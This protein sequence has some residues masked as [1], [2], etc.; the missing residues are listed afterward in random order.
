MSDN[1][2]LDE[3]DERIMKGLCV[4]CGERKSTTHYL[5]E[6]RHEI[7]VCQPCF[8]IE[9]ETEMVWANFVVEHDRPPS[10]REYLEAGD[11]L[12][13]EEE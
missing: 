12:A 1:I 5:W 7:P 2:V 3:F 6:A 8:D 13:G 11:C 10:L 4:E 9:N